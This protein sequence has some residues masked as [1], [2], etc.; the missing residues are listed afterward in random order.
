MRGRRIDAND[1][2][3][4]GEDGGGVGKIVELSSDLRHA[5]FVR[6]QF[7][8]SA[9]QLALNREEARRADRPERS[10]AGQRNRPIAIVHV[11]GVSGPSD[12]Y[13]WP[14]ERLEARTPF[15]DMGIICR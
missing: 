10:E 13:A 11:L 15:S 6:Q 12:C 2:I 7:R 3:D 14:A 8:V 4:E 1:E 9:A 5:R